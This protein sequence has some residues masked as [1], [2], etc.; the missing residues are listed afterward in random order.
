MTKTSQIGGARVDLKAG[1]T[2]M[3]GIIL[4]GVPLYINADCFPDLV[5]GSIPR[6]CLG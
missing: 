1:L 3:I 2:V 5:G 4:S 6:L